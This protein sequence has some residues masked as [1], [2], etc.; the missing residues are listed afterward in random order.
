MAEIFEPQSDHFGGTTP[1]QIHSIVSGEAVT[2]FR[3]C[4]RRY[5]W[6]DLSYYAFGSSGTFAS[7]YVTNRQVGPSTLARGVH[8]Y[9]LPI[10]AG[11]R[12]S[13]RVRSVPLTRYIYANGASFVGYHLLPESEIHTTMSRR[14]TTA[15][16]SG[17]QL[18]ANQTEFEQLVDRTWTGQSI[19]LA[20]QGSITAVELP[21][22]STRRFSTYLDALAFRHVV[23]YM[24]R[25]AQVFVHGNIGDEFFVATGDDFNCFFFLGVPAIWHIP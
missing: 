24:N 10:Y 22:Y 7:A 23:Y 12:G 3:Q 4:M 2:S 20:M 14:K 21:Y 25:L 16:S 11:W 5:S 6:F 18:V 8:G 1:P 9:V 17:F 19:T 15:A 13:L